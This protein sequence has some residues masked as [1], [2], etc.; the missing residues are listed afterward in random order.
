MRSLRAFHLGR[1]LPS[2]FRPFLY[3]QRHKLGLGLRIAS[4]GQACQVHVIG[5]IVVI[6]LK[7]RMSIG[8]FRLCRTPL[9]QRKPNPWIDCHHS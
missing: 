7:I 2:R 6:D 3:H 8:D 9:D 4:L 5:Q 1:G